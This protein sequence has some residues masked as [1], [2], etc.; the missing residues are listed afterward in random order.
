MFSEPY[1][2]AGYSPSVVGITLS[3]AVLDASGAFVGV[4]A[5]D[6]SINQLKAA[7]NKKVYKNG[8]I[9]LATKRGNAVIHPK[10]KD[11]DSAVKSLYQ[12]EFTCED[13]SIDE[14]GAEKYRLELQPRMFKVDGATS[15][16]ESSPTEKIVEYE[17][18]GVS[19]T[20]QH[21]PP[22]TGPTQDS[23][24]FKHNARYAR[25]LL[26]STQNSST[27]FTTDSTQLGFLVHRI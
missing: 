12:T 14:E 3:K 15:V 22:T 25:C 19:Q 7:T 9:V 4:A 10:V 8:Y 20:T 13:G 26:E 24:Y 16:W 21:H 2:F 6:L 17:R 18:C 1:E 27:N 5:L 23:H 11:S